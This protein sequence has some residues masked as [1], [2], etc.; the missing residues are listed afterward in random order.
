MSFSR[1][2]RGCSPGCREDLPCEVP[3]SVL[4]PPC[5]ED[6]L[7]LPLGTNQEAP[8]HAAPPLSEPR[9]LNRGSGLG[10]GCQEWAPGTC[11]GKNLLHCSAHSSKTKALLSPSLC[12]QVPNR[13]ERDT[14]EEGETSTALQRS[15][16]SH[17]KQPTQPEQGVEGRLRRVFRFCLCWVCYM[18]CVTCCLPHCCACLVLRG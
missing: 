12:G 4:S 6:L 11:P 17:P 8:S 2:P 1:A 7:Y 10:L 14:W 16:W 9:G 3:S 5:G 15:C 18:V 13:K